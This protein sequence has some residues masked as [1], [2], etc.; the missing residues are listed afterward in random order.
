MDKLKQV[1]IEGY[2]VIKD[3]ADEC[4]S[5]LIIVNPIAGTSKLSLKGTYQQENLALALE[6]I[7]LVFPDI[8]QN[9]IDEGLKKVKHPC[10]FEY[11]KDKN[12][13]IDGAHNPNG[14]RELKRSLDL[15]FPN[16][17]RRFV[18]GC[19]DTKDYA[20]MIKVLFNENDEI[21]FYH[22]N[23]PRSVPFEKLNAVCKYKSKEFKSLNEFSKDN[24]TLTIICGSFYMINE[25]LKPDLLAV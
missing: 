1:F 23:N 15:Y 16:F 25:I 20:E 21:Y 2:E 9:I 22:F 17:K 18:F 5:L 14:I 24:E 8:S 3:R 7:S 6:A 19:L 10:R 12:I 13:L 4:N 11:L